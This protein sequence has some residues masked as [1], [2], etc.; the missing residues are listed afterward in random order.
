MMKTQMNRFFAAVV[1][2]QLG[3]LFGNLSA[4][5]FGWTDQNQ[6]SL[7]CGDLVATLVV[8]TFTWLVIHF[9]YK[10][11]HRSAEHRRHQPA[12]LCQA[13]AAKVAACQACDGEGKIVC[14]TCGEVK[15]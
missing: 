6:V 8:W 10:E 15:T 1:T 11:D 2:W 4:Q 14:T 9:T 7:R 3:M 12:G 5:S 13:D